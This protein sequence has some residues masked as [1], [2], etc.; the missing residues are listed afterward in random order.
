[1]KDPANGAQPTFRL[2]GQDI[3]ADLVVDFWILVQMRVWADI[4]AGIPVI[5]SV[6]R[7]R[8]ALGIPLYQPCLHHD[9]LDGA[10]RIAWDMRAWP[11]RRLAD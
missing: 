5:E 6:E 3:T 2:L 8:M 4:N 1:M 7:V 9:K 10:S 11:Q